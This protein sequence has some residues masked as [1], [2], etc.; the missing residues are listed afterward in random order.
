MPVVATAGRL[1]DDRPAD[2][3]TESLQARSV[4]A[5]PPNRGWRSERAGQALAHQQFVLSVLQRVRPGTHQRALSD[6]IAQDAGGYMLVI[7]GDH[8]AAGGELAHR[9]V[10][11]VVADH[12]VLDHPCRPDLGALGQQAQVHAQ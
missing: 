8:V 11:G 7:E 4:G 3:I 5:L 6:Q 2:L 12:H 9:C 10:V 1:G